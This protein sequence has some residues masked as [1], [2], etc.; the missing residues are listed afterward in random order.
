MTKPQE[1]VSLRV[2]ALVRWFALE[3]SVAIVNQLHEKGICHDYCR[4]LE[5][6]NALK[7]AIEPVLAEYLKDEDGDSCL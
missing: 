4:S 5:F 6:L 1:S 2:D 7:N 3:Q